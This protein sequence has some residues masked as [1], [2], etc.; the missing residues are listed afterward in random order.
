M[1]N[2]SREDQSEWCSCLF[3]G[4][5]DIGS[6]T[7]IEDT[8]P[9]ADRSSTSSGLLRLEVAS[10]MWGTEKNC[11]DVTKDIAALIEADELT[12]P[13][14]LKFHKV[15]GDPAVSKVVNLIALS[16]PLLR[17]HESAILP[18]VFS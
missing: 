18:R 15:F 7:Q 13:R 6:S 8:F 4:C 16:S 2:N 5:F 3:N 17:L 11:V 1:A 12:I 10:A 14:G 9:L